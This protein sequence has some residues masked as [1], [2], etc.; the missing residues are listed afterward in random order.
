VVIGVLGGPALI[1]R[2]LTGF[3][4]SRF[5]A[6]ALLARILGRRLEALAAMTALPFAMTFHNANH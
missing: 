5:A 2:K 1:G 3:F 4:T 6:I